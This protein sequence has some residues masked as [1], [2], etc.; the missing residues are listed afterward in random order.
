MVGLWIALE[1]ADIEN[2]CLW[3]VPKSHKNSL[4]VKMIF[5]TLEVKKQTIGSLPVHNPEDFVACPAKKGLL[6]LIDGLV[7]HRSGEN[8]SNQP[9]H[10]YTMMLGNQ[11]GVKTTGFSLIVCPSLCSTD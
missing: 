7:L 5:T 9:R 3:F 11:S 10:V 4:G 8:T 1:D 6:V 2:S